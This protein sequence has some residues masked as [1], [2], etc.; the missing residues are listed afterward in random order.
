MPSASSAAAVRRTTSP[1]VAGEALTPRPRGSDRG[2]ERA[3]ALLG[4]K[5]LRELL[6]VAVEHLVEAV[7]ACA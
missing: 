2:L 1:T 4:L 5:R 3:A 7:D 6:E